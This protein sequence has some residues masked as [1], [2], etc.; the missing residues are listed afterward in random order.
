M[1]HMACKLAITLLISIQY[2]SHINEILLRIYHFTAIR[3]TMASS[4]L[5]FTQSPSGK[6]K[7]AFLN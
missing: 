3:P 4:Y 7:E 6:G 5:P 2:Q 1:V